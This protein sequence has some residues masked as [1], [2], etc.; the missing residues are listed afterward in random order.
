MLLQTTETL[1]Q[2][3][4]ISESYSMIFLN[5]QIEISNKGLLRGIFEGQRNEYQEAMDNF[6]ILAP[7][8]ANAIIGIKVSSAIQQFQNGTFQYLTFIGTPVRYSPVE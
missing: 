7:R 2:G 6:A 5:T 8:E 3:F 4:I 1:P